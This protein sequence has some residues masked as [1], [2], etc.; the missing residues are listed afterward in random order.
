MSLQPHLGTDPSDHWVKAN[1]VYL[2]PGELGGQAVDQPF[3]MEA[4]LLIHPPS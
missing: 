1:A 3:D 2:E 4:M